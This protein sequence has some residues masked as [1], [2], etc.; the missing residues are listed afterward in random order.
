LLKIVNHEKPDIIIFDAMCPWGWYVGQVLRIP[1]VSSMALLMLTP[2]MFFQSGQFIDLAMLA[3]RNFSHIRT[4]N[5]IAARMSHAHNIKT[6]GFPGL[7]TSTGTITVS[8][9]STMFQPNGENF[10]ESIKF[11]GPAVEPRTDKS[12]FPFDQLGEKPV[13][14]ISLGTVINNNP[15]FYKQCLR[16]FANADFRVVMSVGRRIDIASL[17]E[18]PAKFIV[19]NF[20]PQLDILQH[21]SLFITHA[22]MNSVHEGL[23]YNVPLLLTPQQAEQNMVANCVQ[24]LGAGIKLSAPPITDQQLQENVDRILNDGSFR[25]RA[26]AVGESF[27]AAGG[28]K[29]AADEI[30]ALA[31]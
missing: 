14:Y 13:L 7:L 23:Y 28:Y 12:D 20:V 10:D 25:A 4:A 26:K 15:E 6:S 8:Y 2:G 31:H 19:R 3:V 17:G 18:I 30:M 22:G 29:R 21:T 9:T 5:S 1:S 11:V 16:V 27:R 24:R